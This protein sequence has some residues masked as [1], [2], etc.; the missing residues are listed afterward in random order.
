MH[1]SQFTNKI[2]EDEAYRM[3]DYRNYLKYL[4]AE[5]MNGGEEPEDFYIW[6]K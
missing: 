3:S 1:K 5:Y 2:D 4:A 6:K